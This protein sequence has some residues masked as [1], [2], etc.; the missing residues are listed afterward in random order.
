MPKAKS[1]FRNRNRNRNCDV[2]TDG[3]SLRRG[4]SG[5]YGGIGVFYGDGDSRNLS[6]RL[7]CHNQ[8]SKRAEIAA[9]VAALIQAKDYIPR[10]LNI[11]SDSV[12]AIQ[13]ITLNLDN[14][15]CKTGDT[16]NELI[17]NG[18]KCHKELTDLKVNITF[19]KVRAHSVVYGNVQADKLAK[20]GATMD[21]IAS[22]IFPG[23]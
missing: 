2:Y 14:P 3:S 16:N 21:K 11:Y 17:Q 22:D 7:C 8:S 10:N 13:L 1:S 9:I 5:M 15:S 19:N 23:F 20:E 18:V 12:E 4:I 6:R